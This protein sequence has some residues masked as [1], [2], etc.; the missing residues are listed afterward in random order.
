M[1]PIPAWLI[2]AEALPSKTSKYIS[3]RGKLQGGKCHCHGDSGKPQVRMLGR[4]DRAP[5]IQRPFVS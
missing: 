5:K 3:A 2:L 1:F 4:V